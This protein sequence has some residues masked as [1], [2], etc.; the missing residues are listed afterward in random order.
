MIKRIICVMLAVAVIVFSS[1]TAFAATDGVTGKCLKVYSYTVGEQMLRVDMDVKHALKPETEYN[2]SFCYT[3]G[4]AHTS[5]KW[6][7]GVSN[8]EEDKLAAYTEWNPI[9]LKYI[10]DL[11]IQDDDAE[12]I[13]TDIVWLDDEVVKCTFN[14][15]TPSYVTSFG[16][17]N[18]VGVGDAMIDNIH[19]ES[20]DGSHVY[21]IDF[22]KGTLAENFVSVEAEHELTTRNASSGGNKTENNSSNAQTGNVVIGA[23]DDSK[24]S[25]GSKDTQSKNETTESKDTLNGEATQSGD[26]ASTNEN[27][28]SSAD[29]TQDNTTD[30]DKNA[31]KSDSDSKITTADFSVIEKTVK[32]F[33]MLM[34]ILIAAV[35]V[36]ILGSVIVLILVIK[37]LK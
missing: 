2:V 15:T 23:G 12:P 4:S 9:D 21:D 24:V 17:T 32:N 28:D 7:F 29:E 31:D 6:G 18:Q 3:L 26:S 19:V 36:A 5:T 27:V 10:W 14:F 37:K 20:I 8:I 30:S 16:S 33:N 34:I 25:S 1:I 13:F 35:G 22:E 11:T